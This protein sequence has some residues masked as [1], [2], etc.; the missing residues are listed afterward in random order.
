MSTYH[1]ELCNSLWFFD[2]S[3]VMEKEADT[4]MEEEEGQ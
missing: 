2:Y 3:D 1:K 4:E